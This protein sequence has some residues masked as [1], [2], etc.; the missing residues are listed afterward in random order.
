MEYISFLPHEYTAVHCCYIKNFI[1][2][3]E[4]TIYQSFY[5]F[6]IL[7]EDDKTCMYIVRMLK[8]FIQKRESAQPIYIPICFIVIQGAL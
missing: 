5:N 6:I 8:S 3:S 7:Y 2:H 1:F 4:S